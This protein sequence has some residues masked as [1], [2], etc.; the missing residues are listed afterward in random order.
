MSLNES[1]VEDAALTWFGELGY[2]VGHG[3][4]LAPGEPAAER[5]S[6]G[7]VVLVGRLREAIRRMNPAIP[8][9]RTLATLRDT[10]LPK[11]LSGELS[12]TETFRI[13]N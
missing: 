11:L 13:P 8:Q 5:D 6:F 12:I 1:I 2:A 7:E 10:L 4:H 3:P 9:A